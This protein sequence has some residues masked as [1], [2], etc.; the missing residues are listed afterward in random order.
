MSY[1]N[2]SWSTGLINELVHT[3]S[4]HSPTTSEREI[5]RESMQ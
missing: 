3:Y 4:L 2:V 5:V 1:I